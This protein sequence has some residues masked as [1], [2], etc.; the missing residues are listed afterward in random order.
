M[1]SS[2]DQNSLGDK[3]IKFVRK[4]G[5]RSGEMPEDFGMIAWI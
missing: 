5:N 1:T 3:M 4:K 2:D